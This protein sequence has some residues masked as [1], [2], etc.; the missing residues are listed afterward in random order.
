MNKRNYDVRR[1][2]FWL[3]T[4]TAITIV[5]SALLTFVRSG[6]LHPVR[7]V[8]TLGGLVGMWS[9]YFAIVRDLRAAHGEIAENLSN[10]VE[11]SVGLCCFLGYMLADAAMN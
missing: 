2:M 9:I 3:V 11:T 7:V 4:L 8:G 10:R 5:A 6:F 1:L